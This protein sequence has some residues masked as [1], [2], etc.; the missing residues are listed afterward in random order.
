MSY[1]VD[2]TYILFAISFQNGLLSGAPFICSYIASVFF[3]YIAD[4]VVT[5][6]YI[7]LTNCRKIMTA[8]CEY[9]INANIYFLIVS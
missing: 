2:E 7:S 5:L 1:I 9:F 3:C 6:Q 4:K 8:L